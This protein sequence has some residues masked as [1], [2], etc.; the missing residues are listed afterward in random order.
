MGNGVTLALPR[1]RRYPAAGGLKSL[2]EFIGRENVS[3]VYHIASPFAF[4][5]QPDT[6]LRVALTASASRSLFNRQRGYVLLLQI[7][8]VPHLRGSLRWHTAERSD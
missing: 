2:G 7:L 5:R 3:R 4:V 8:F 1:H 6:Q